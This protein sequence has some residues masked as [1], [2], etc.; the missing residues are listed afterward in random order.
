[1][2]TEYRQNKG[3]GNNGVLDP[4]TASERLPTYRVKVGDQPRSNES[5]S[6]SDYKEK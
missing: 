1:M 5:N 2:P 3:K 4:G 6:S